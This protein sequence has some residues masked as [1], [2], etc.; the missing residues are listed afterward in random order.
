MSAAI[1]G[2][3]GGVFGLEGLR[4][5]LGGAA[6]AADVL[7][8]SSEDLSSFFFPHKKRCLT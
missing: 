8:K 4:R 3:Y 5:V 7:L 2:D 6:A 1:A